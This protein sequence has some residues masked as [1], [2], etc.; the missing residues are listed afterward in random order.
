MKPFAVICILVL[1]GALVAPFFITVN[2]QPLLS[3]DKVLSDMTPDAVNT[4]TEVYRWQDENGSWHFGEAPPAA[5]AAERVRVDDRITP[6][7]SGW[8]VK[9]LTE[10]GTKSSL[11]MTAPGIAG[12]VQGGQALMDKAA[13]EVQKLNERTDRMASMRRGLN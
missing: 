12:Y 10:P 5:V 13:V 1:L 7:D 8:H 9:P 6:M 11:G 4:P 2:G 3:L